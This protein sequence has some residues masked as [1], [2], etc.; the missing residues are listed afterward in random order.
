MAVRRAASS[1]PVLHGVRRVTREV[2][3]TVGAVV[4]LA[5]I[6]ALAAALLFDL[7]ALV[8]E[9]GSMSPS[10]ETG[11]LAV[12]RRIPAAQLEVG[13][14]VSVHT[15]SGDRV[16]HRIVGLDHRGDRALLT[17]K[18]DAN[19]V[20]DPE[21]YDV[22]AADRVVVSAPRLGYAAA[23]VAS[24]AGLVLMGAYAIF[25]VS[26]ILRPEGHQA[27][28]RHR[29][30]RAARSRRG[31]QL[32]SRVA[33]ARPRW[34]KRLAAALLVA[35][36]VVTGV[37]SERTSPTL[38]SFT[39][40]VQTS[41][42]TLSAATVAPP[43]T[44]TCGL[45]GAFSVTFNWTAVSGATSYTLHYGTNGAQTVTTTSTSATLTAA[46]TGGKAWVTT[47]RAFGTTWT[48]GPSVTRNYSVALV[49]LCA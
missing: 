30:P 14:I 42:P 38:A 8:F 3:L 33:A 32:P 18:G 48:S 43:A 17:L 6:L 46:L 5:G 2:V 1:A 10:I 29:A 20:A 25:L 21:R 27:A 9:S 13:D 22:V 19:A 31:R 11:A 44:F 47:N 7:R 15:A 37:T 12:A 45:L 36:T 16:T 35:A 4:G 39:D 41:G 23:R 34:L 28:G 40:S 26:V 49:S 24:P